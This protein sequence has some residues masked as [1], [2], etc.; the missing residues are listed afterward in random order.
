MGG[1]RP[2]GR[3]G[4]ALSLSSGVRPGVRDKSDVA[5]FAQVLAWD[6]SSSDIVAYIDALSTLNDRCAQQPET[7]ATDY[8]T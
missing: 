6:D 3:P 5:T 8:S 4:D 2:A 7:I 1:R